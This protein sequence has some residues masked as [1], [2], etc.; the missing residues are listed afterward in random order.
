MSD[1]NW[2]VYAELLAVT[3]VVLSLFFVGYE[4]RTNSAIARSESYN[5]FA[6]NISEHARVLA[7]DP[8]IAP[9]LTRVNAGDVPSDFDETE[10]FRV[11]NTY[12]SNLRIWEGLFR[13]V[14]EGILTQDNLEMIGQ[15]GA[16]NNPYFRS[17]WFGGMR[18]GYSENFVDVF[19]K[20]SWNIQQ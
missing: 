17:V 4:L 3:S 18:E 12:A 8:I 6:F 15:G 20:L 14:D 9:L 2:R 10:T 5:S 1:S 11:N 16:F 19:E 13:S 7:T